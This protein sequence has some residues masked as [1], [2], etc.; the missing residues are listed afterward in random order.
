MFLQSFLT[1]NVFVQAVTVMQE[2]SNG[3]HDICINIVCVYGYGGQDVC[4]NSVCVCVCVCTAMGPRTYVL[5]Y[6]CVQL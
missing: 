2:C 6:V 4:I 3:G 5:M 1:E